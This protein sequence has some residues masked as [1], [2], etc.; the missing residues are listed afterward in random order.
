MLMILILLQKASVYDLWAH[1]D[2]GTMTGKVTATVATHGVAMY[3]IK[4]EK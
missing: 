1:K 3:R 4:P 2:M